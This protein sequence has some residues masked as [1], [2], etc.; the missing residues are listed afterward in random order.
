VLT[1]PKSG[2]GFGDQPEHFPLYFNHIGDIYMPE[3]I[4]KNVRIDADLCD[5]LRKIADEEHRSFEAVLNH[6][7]RAGLD[8]NSESTFEGRVN[9]LI[10]L[11]LAELA[12]IN[13]HL[14]LR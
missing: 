4:Q 1:H 10:Q 7:L 8:R 14:R 12:R 11:K 5:H 9:V 6:Y 13:P 2:T 3:M